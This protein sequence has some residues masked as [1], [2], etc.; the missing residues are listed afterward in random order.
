MHGV[1][2]CEGSMFKSKFANALAVMI[3]G[4]L[5]IVRRKGQV[6]QIVQA[7]ESSLT[8]VGPRVKFS[9][10]SISPKPDAYRL[11]FRIVEVGV[12]ETG[13]PGRLSRFLRRDGAEESHM[14]DLNM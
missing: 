1:I 8:G 10:C 13:Q 2:A 12:N 14:N 11:Q 4:S 3:I 7:E 6:R 9:A 5:G